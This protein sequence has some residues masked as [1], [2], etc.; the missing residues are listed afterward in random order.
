M[1][2]DRVLRKLVQRNWFGF[3]PIINVQIREQLRNRQVR[4][5][6]ATQRRAFVSGPRDR[7]RI[8]YRFDSTCRSRS[9]QWFDRVERSGVDENRSG[10]E[11]A[12]HTLTSID[13]IPADRGTHRE[14]MPL[15]HHAMGITRPRCISN[16]RGPRVEPHLE[17]PASFAVSVDHSNRR[18]ATRSFTCSAHAAKLVA[19]TVCGRLIAT[20]LA[21]SR[22]VGDA[23]LEPTTST[24]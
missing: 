12:R 18:R 1:F 16:V 4:D 9:A 15:T 2:D 5:A 13:E 20:T 14:C 23:G 3:E 17:G 21:S 10:H 8:R 22:W 11:Q 24:V 7:I 6:L 19:S